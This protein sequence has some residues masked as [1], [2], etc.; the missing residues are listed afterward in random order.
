MS[1]EIAA[2]TNEINEVMATG[3][4][5][6]IANDYLTGFTRTMI[7]LDNSCEDLDANEAATSIAK[8]ANVMSTNQGLF[9]NIGS[10]I[11]DLGNNFAMTEKPIME[12]A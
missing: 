9:Q 7:D 8:F 12:M 10:T 4:Q 1:T 3:G 5:L 6:G 2:S 11:V